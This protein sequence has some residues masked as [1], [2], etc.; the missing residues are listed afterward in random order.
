[1]YHIRLIKGLSYTGAVKATKKEPDVFVEDKAT[2]ETAVASG[3]FTMVGEEEPGTPDGEPERLEGHL[4]KEQ[5]ESMTVDNLKKLAAD[6]GIETKGMKRRAE[7][8]EAILAVEVTAGAESGEPE[9][10]GT[11]DGE[12]ENGGIDYGEGEESTGSPTMFELQ[13]K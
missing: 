9:E 12:P 5:L 3:Y 8:V 6:M 4:A 7:F 13:E 2:A 1:M 10:P 11:P